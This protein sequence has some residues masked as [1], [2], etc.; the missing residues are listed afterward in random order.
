MEVF[1]F[2]SNPRNANNNKNRILEK[3]FFYR[4]QINLLLSAYI[5]VFVVILQLKI[6]KHDRRIKQ[7]G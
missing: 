2:I 7:T 6:D 4:K 1:L 3:I 5:R